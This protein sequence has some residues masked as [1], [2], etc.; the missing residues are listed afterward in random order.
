MARFPFGLPKGWF[1]VGYSHELEVGQVVPLRYFNKDLVLFRGED[2]VARVWDA[3]CPHLGAHLGHGGEVSGNGLVCPFHAWRFD[4]EGNCAE[5]P[6]SDKVPK[7]AKMPCWPVHE[8]ASLIM[9][10]FH[11]HGGAPEWECPHIPEGESDDWTDFYCKRWQIETCNQEMAENA[12]DSAHFMYLHGTQEV[13]VTEATIDG[14]LLH[15][16]SPAAM[17][18]GGNRVDGAINSHCWGFGWT[19]TRFTG[20]VE[21]LLFCS[22]TPIDLDNVD[23]RFSFSV[24]KIG[25]AD[26]TKGVGKAFVAEVSRQLEQDIPIWENKEYLP[27]PVLCKGD[28]PVGKFRVW[29]KQF[30]PAAAQAK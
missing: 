20:I 7:Q 22:T 8:Q 21:T 16:Y 26:I 15:C 4:G 3:H 27:R 17:T 28:G 12:V 6:Y 9:V 11:P 18:A 1:Q 2:G 14:P 25:G 13:P 5:I 19:T 23:V 10:W 24:K 30:Y 29:A